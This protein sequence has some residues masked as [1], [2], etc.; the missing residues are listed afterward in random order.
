MTPEEI[1]KLSD[2]KL[3]ELI[4][5]KRGYENI[6]EALINDEWVKGSFW[7]KQGV[8]YF[9]KHAPDYCTSWQ[10][11]GELLEE[12]PN[13]GLCPALIYDD[14]GH[15]AVA[16]DGTQTL[17]LQEGT[18]DVYTSFFVKKEDWKDSPTR[19]IAESWAMWS[20]QCG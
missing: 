2:E 7:S 19:A 15:W 4:A 11:A 6:P 18:N 8:G 14:D 12:M 16:N 20:E 17:S 5:V 1:S 9:E 3:N 10:Y 13:T